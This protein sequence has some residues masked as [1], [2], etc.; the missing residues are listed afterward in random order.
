MGKKSEVPGWA[1]YIITEWRAA[2]IV[3]FVMPMSFLARQYNCVCNWIHER[4][5][6]DATGHEGRVARV[7]EEVRRW[8][9]LP[10]AGRKMLCTDRNPSASHS[11]RFT[12]KHL[13]REYIDMGTLLLPAPV[14]PSS[15]PDH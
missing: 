7:Q 15:C 13:W 12:P 2:I 10:A 1:L 5:L 11:V 8:N 4:F 14:F 3:L 6:A 9:E